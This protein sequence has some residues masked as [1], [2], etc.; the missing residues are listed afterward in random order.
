MCRLRSNNRP[1]D[2]GV[3]LVMGVDRR[4]RWI[5]SLRCFG[6]EKL[7]HYGRKVWTHNERDP[8][9]HKE[10]LIVNSKLKN[11]RLIVWR[12][13]LICGSFIACDRD[14]R[15]ASSPRVELFHKWLQA[16]R[17]GNLWSPR[18]DSF[19]LHCFLPWPSSGRRAVHL[20]EHF[21]FFV[22]N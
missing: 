15:F 10:S 14:G 1:F 5:D 7:W 3:S 9:R 6:A 2:N 19:L 21:A 17:F 13:F 16:L 4:L 11:A 22:N 8:V 18:I 20:R 12:F